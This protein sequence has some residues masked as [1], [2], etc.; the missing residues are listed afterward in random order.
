MTYGISALQNINDEVV[1]D[2]NY[3]NFRVVAQGTVTVQSNVIFN[4]P[5]V[6]ITLPANSFAPVVFLQAR[7]FVMTGFYISGGV[8][9]GGLHT[10]VSLGTSLAYAV[11]DADLTDDNPGGYGIAILDAAGRTVFHSQRTYMRVVQGFTAPS[12]GEFTTESVDLINGYTAMHGVS[13]VGIQFAPQTSPPTPFI[14]VQAAVRTSSTN[15]SVNAIR[16]VPP[17]GTIATQTVNPTFL[18]ATL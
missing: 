16:A 13:V 14:L 5:G 10:S 1:I 15:I 6:V 11:C 9:Y 8:Y 3:R 2:A 17:N 18:L 12:A 4:Q 7:D